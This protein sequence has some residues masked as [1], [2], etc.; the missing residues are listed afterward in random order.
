MRF[1]D[2]YKR[3]EKVCEEIL[4]DERRISAYIEE[5]LKVPDGAKVVPG[6]EE[7]LKQ[8]KRYRWVRNQIVHNPDCTENEMCD[9]K[10]VRWLTQFHARIMDETDPL[11]RYYAALKP[12]S[13]PETT[14][15]VKKSKR[16]KEETKATL[17]VIEI[18]DHHTDSGEAL[19]QE[20]EREVLGRPQKTAK[21]KKKTKQKRYR[22]GGCVTFLGVLLV[23]VALVIV[24]LILM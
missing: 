24:A 23:L 15:P 3:L 14:K 16:T 11:T 13:I 6:W 8:L 18:I 22:N 5:M 21:K 12:K 2:A 19:V 7:D 1:M 9:S 10:D 20:R 17:K 4:D